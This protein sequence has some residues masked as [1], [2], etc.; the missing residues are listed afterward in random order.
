MIYQLALGRRHEI[1]IVSRIGTDDGKIN[2]LDANLVTSDRLM[3][4]N[5]SSQ[6]T[7]VVCYAGSWPH[8]KSY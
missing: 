1:A 3:P 7:N 6:L 8:A 2:R 5:R 4:F